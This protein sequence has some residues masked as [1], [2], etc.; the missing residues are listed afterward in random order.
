[1]ITKKERVDWAIEDI[2]IKKDKLLFLKEQIEKLANDYQNL[3]L[4]ILSQ[5]I[6]IL[7]TITKEEK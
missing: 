7:T 2:E 1:M 3:E 4:E 5:Q 6:Q